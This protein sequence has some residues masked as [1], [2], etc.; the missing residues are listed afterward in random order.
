V[1][2]A[3]LNIQGWSDLADIATVLS[4]PV[5]VLAVIMTGRQ[6][7]AQFTASR[8]EAS[9]EVYLR[10][11]EKFSDLMALQVELAERFEARDKS[12][13]LKSVS[14]YYVQYWIL[15]INHWE[16]FRAGL[17]PVGVYASWLVYTHDSMAGDALLGYF[18]ARGKPQSLS[19][20][21]A[22]ETI[23]LRRMLRGQPEGAA[24]FREL[25]AIPHGWSREAGFEIQDEPDLDVRLAAITA[26]VN[27]RQADYRARPL[28]KIH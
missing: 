24:F 22:F 4:L 12:L 16:M 15:Q 20:K 6:I 18:D 23:F 28:W 25:A 17:L 1:I 7:A 19:S 14:R 13:N 8:R 21:A 10:F 9:F 27:A 26:L 3:G 5:I 2:L 11:A